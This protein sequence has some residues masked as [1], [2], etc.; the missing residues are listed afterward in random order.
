MIYSF[1]NNNPKEVAVG[2]FSFGSGQK[3]SGKSG[4][5]SNVKVTAKTS[6]SGKVTDVLVSHSGNPHKNHVHYYQ[7]SS[8]WWG[9]SKKGKG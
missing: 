9:S 7:K 5:V 6:R 1:C 2:W 3:S 8:G 4:K